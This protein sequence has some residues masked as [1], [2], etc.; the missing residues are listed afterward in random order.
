MWLDNIKELR[1]E[2]GMSVKQIAE[3]AN[4]P[5]RTVARIFSGDT[6]TPYVDTLYR[7]AVILGGSLDDILADSKTVVGGKNLVVLEEEVDGLQGELETLKSE[8]ELLSA[9]N[10]MLKDKVVTL[11]AEND[12]LRLK[13]DHKEEI[14]SL[15]NYYI[16][17]NKNT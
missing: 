16:K 9:E 7:I 8:Y 11:T 17:L 4:L 6:H 3:A 13:L 14:I 5:E 1:K 15:H 2:K 10:A 12:I